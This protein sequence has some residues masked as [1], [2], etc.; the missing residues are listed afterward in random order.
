MAI[1]LTKLNS[2][3]LCIGIYLTS[4]HDKSSIESYNTE[5]NTLTS[6]IKTHSDECEILL[7]GDFQTFPSVIYDDAIRNNCK[8]NPL[9]K[10]LYLF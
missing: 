6:L 3:Y 8:R 5:L 9:S 10:P 4:Y 2:T 1:K 7:I